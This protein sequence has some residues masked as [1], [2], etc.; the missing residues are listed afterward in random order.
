MSDYYTSGP[1]ALV[2]GIITVKIWTIQSLKV[3][4]LLSEQKILYVQPDLC[5][6]RP[7]FPDAYSWMCQKMRERL[8]DYQEH[9]P[10]WG[11]YQPKPDLRFYSRKGVN[12]TQWV[13]IELDIPTSKVLLSYESAWFAVL[14]GLFVAYTDAE[15]E[16]WDQEID[17][18][19]LNEWRRPLPEPWESQLVKSWDNIF[20]LNNL[21]NS[22]GWSNII[23][24]NFEELRLADVVAVKHFKVRSSVTTQ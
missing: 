19:G 20:D 8:P 11:W 1:V 14:N 17:E 15:Y 9:L 10:W 4:E 21:N 22:G 12:N 5:E 2:R 6:E 7:S 13:R 16:K 24:A 3:W 18:R 23:Q